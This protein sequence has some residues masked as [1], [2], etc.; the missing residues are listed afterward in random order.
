M[1]EQAPQGIHLTE[2][3][4]AQVLQAIGEGRVRDLDDTPYDAAVWDEEVVRDWLERTH[5]PT[6]AR[7]IVSMLRN[8]QRIKSRPVAPTVNIAL[9]LLF[10]RIEHLEREVAELRQQDR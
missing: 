4:V 6:R 9:R 1:S 8:G 3:D 7:Q 5:F 2:D 10:A